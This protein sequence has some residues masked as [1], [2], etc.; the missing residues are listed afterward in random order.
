[1]GMHTQDHLKPNESWAHT[2]NTFAS[3]K[4]A[5]FSVVEYSA[6]QRT[7]FAGAD[8]NERNTKCIRTNEVGWNALDSRIVLKTK[9]NKRK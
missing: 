4:A 5:H 3:I 9:M 1:M 7:L 6:S 2:H 8:N